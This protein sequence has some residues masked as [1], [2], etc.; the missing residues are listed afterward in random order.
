MTRFLRNTVRIKDESSVGAGA[1]AG[2]ERGYEQ[3]VEERERQERDL[4][5][6]LVSTV[7]DQAHLVPL[8]QR[9][10]PVLWDHDHSLSLYPMPTAVSIPTPKSS[11]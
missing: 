6:F 5:K 10:R 2:G 7:L 1:G 3:E 9:I 4:K 8:A 11:S